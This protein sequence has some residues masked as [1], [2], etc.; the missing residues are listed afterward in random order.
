M[1]KGY[2]SP[3]LAFLKD[4]WDT[5][6]FINDDLEVVWNASKS[7]QLKL[8]KKAKIEE[9]REHYNPSFPNS[10]FHEKLLLFQNLWKPDRQSFNFF[11]CMHHHLK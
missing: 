8:E 11:A 3:V 5:D 4:C 1:G 10:Q 9:T 2:K 7:L 6:V